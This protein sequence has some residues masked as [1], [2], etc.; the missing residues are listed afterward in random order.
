MNIHSTIY[1]YQIQPIHKSYALSNMTSYHSSWCVRILC[2]TYL[3]LGQVFLYYI[4]ESFSPTPPQLRSCNLL[5][6]ITKFSLL[7]TYVHIY[8]RTYRYFT[9]YVCTYIVATY[10]LMYVHESITMLHYVVST[11]VCTYVSM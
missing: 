6:L 11:Y 10:I 1:T 5:V 7:R 3:E 9:M 8:I 2:Y 4:G